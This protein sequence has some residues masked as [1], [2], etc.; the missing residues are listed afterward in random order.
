MTPTL[1]NYLVWL[2]NPFFRWWWAALTGAVTLMG[3]VWTPNAG[4]NLSRPV[5]LLLIFTFLSVTFLA[6]STVTQGWRLYFQRTHPLRVLEARRAK[7]FNSDLL[8]VLSGH[9]EESGGALLEIRRSLENAELPFCV[10]KV[11]GST[12]EGHYQAIPVWISP[13]HLRAFTR[14]EFEARDLRVRSTLTYDRI[15]EVFDE[16]P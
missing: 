10:V 5:F 14:H 2:F 13:G 15:R 1:A 12:A 9:L 16:T 11:V 4:F 7:D 6:L 3:F 8:F